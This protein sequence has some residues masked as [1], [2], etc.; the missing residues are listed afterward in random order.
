MSLET[1]IIPEKIFVGFQERANTYSGKL[2]YVIYKDHKGV[3][4]KKESW[5][6]WCSNEMDKQELDNVPMSGFVLNRDVGGVRRSYGW[7]QRMEKVRVYD[8]RGFEIEITIPNMLFIFQECSSIKGKG[9]EGEF[10]YS[11][12]GPNLILLPVCSKE[13]KDST[14][15]TSLIK[16]KVSSKDLKEGA[17]YLTKEHKKLLYMGRHI[18]FDKLNKYGTIDIKGKKIYVFVDA[19]DKFD[20]IQHTWETEYDSKRRKYILMT[21]L[22]KVAEEI[23]HEHPDYAEENQKMHELGCISACKR[24]YDMPI[25]GSWEPR[26]KKEICAKIDGKLYVGDIRSPYNRG[27]YRYG[28]NEGVGYFKSEVIIEKGEYKAKMLKQE[29]VIEFPYSDL[30]TNFCELWVE[31]ENGREPVKI[32]G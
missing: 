1:L 20:A 2:A 19:S 3:L 9:I 30:K 13:Y 11:W 12:D 24:L 6:K 4:R 32:I 23:L 28:G 14:S 27:F 22:D 29:L 16:Q 17:V 7:D 18:W 10:V 31:F 25:T 8:P 21:G 26:W 15:H 5:E